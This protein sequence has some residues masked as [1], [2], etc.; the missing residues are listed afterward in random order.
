M[1]PGG[2]GEGNHEAMLKRLGAQFNAASCWSRVLWYGV[3]C[4]VA[5]AQKQPLRLETI[6]V[7]QG[8]SAA[9]AQCLAQDKRDFLWVG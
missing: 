7:E 2:S 6:S 4:L 9:S 3:F 8:L 5:V 1:R